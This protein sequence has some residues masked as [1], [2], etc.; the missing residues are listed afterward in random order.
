MA[1][2]DIGGGVVGLVEVEGVGGF[3]MVYSSI[4]K[5]F[6]RREYLGA[7]DISP[8]RPLSPPSRRRCARYSVRY[9][10]TSHKSVGFRSIKE[11]RHS[12]ES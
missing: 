8:L 11:I 1:R 7:K 9:Y 12:I 4:S 6:E 2:Q 10:K 5:V 3:P